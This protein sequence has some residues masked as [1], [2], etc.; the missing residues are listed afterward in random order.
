M[1]MICENTFL[2]FKSSYLNSHQFLSDDVS[3]WTEEESGG[4]AIGNLEHR[5]ESGSTTHGVAR[6]GAIFGPISP[7]RDPD[8]CIT[9]TF[10]SGSPRS[11]EIRFGDPG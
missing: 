6:A 5:R 7:P 11:T 2:I 10:Q 1:G 4:Q 3:R 8:T 9:S